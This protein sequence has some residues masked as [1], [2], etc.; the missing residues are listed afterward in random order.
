VRNEAEAFRNDMVPRARGEAERLIQEAR[1]Y[2]EEIVNRA[3]GD[4]QR[5][6]SVYEAYAKSPDVTQQRIYIE[7]MQ[8]VLGNVQKVIIDDKGG[9]SGVVP[10]LP[11]PEI[12]KRVGQGD[13]QGSTT[14][15]PSANRN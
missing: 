13:S 9:S 7:T 4:A 2:R 5:F 1:A 12:Q 15:A 10:Y 3:Q 14:A 6:L 11:L 8:Q